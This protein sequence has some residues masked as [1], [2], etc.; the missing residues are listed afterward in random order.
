MIFHGIFNFKAAMKMKWATESVFDSDNSSHIGTDEEMLLNLENCM[1]KTNNIKWLALTQPDHS[2]AFS[3]RRLI[4]MLIL[5][6]VAY[7]CRY[8]NMWESES[9]RLLISFPRNANQ[10]TIVPKLNHHKS[11][12]LFM[13]VTTICSPARE[14]LTLALDRCG[15][16]HIR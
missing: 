4:F 7:S 15:V 2:L 3:S 8:L 11:N 13:P 9:W 14:I 12:F 16:C 1:W 6:V 10:D 5:L